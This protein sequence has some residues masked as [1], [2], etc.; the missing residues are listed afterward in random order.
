[1]HLFHMHEGVNEIHIYLDIILV[2][3]HSTM[4]KS[5]SKKD[6]SILASGRGVVGR[7]L[8]NQM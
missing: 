3:P 7:M 2:V 1:M 4:F 6:R 8:G 5:V